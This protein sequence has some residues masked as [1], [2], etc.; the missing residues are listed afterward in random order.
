MMEMDAII[1]AIVPSATHNSGALSNVLKYTL[2][3]TNDDLLR[4]LTNELE[5]MPGIK[6]HHFFNHA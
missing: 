2:P 6:V 5:K 4:H 1:K 3:A